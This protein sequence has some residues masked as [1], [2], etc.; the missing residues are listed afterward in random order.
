MRARCRTEP[1][2][3]WNRLGSF[4]ISSRM[5]RHIG[6]RRQVLRALAWGGAG[7]VLAG[8]GERAEAAQKFAVVRTEA[9]W[10]ARL[11]PAAFAVLR[12][13][14]TER[15][16]T[17]P[18]NDEHRTGTFLCRGC[19]QPLFASRTKFDSG[20]GWPSFWAPLPR[21]VG[22]RQDR[23]WGMARTEVHCS[24]CGGHLGHVFDDGPRPT[25]ERFC[26]N[27]LALRFRP[28]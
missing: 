2:S 4:T 3:R 8:C 18:L 5:E 17:S 28:A 14:E 24:R 20:T 12:R 16:F 21:A 6:D 15:P 7:L 25:G 26:T 27:G 23:S 10:R 11:G 22:S 9:Q 1:R 19:A 13:E